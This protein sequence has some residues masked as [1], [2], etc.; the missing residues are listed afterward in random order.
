MVSEKPVR[1]PSLVSEKPVRVPCMVSE[2]YQ[3][4]LYGQ[5]DPSESPVSQW[6]PS[7]SPAS[8]WDHQNPCM[9][10]DTYQNPL[11]CQWDP[12]ESPGWSVRPSESLYGQWHP[13]ESPVWWVSQKLLYGQWDACQNPLYGPNQNI[14][15]S[16]VRHPLHSQWDSSES[17]TQS[18]RSQSESPGTHIDKCII[19][20]ECNIF[21]SR[22]EIQNWIIAPHFASHLPITNICEEMNSKTWRHTFISKAYTYF[23]V[24]IIVNNSQFNCGVSMDIKLTEHTSISCSVYFTYSDRCWLEGYWYLVVDR[25]QPPTMATP[26]GIK[27]Q[28]GHQ[29][30]FIHI[31]YR[32][33]YVYL[34]NTHSHQD[35]SKLT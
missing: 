21:F 15:V 2:T 34:I 22:K 31:C 35:I 13:S 27:L 30:T 28:I 7:E 9:V 1:A 32:K 20:G 23:M 4:P 5:W 3:N 25:L 18:V 33:F 11:Y 17:P 26:G 6:D 12:S 14:P 29:K 8:Q 16:W 10:S 19:Y 24:L